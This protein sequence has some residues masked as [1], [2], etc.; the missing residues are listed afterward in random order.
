MNQQENNQLRRTLI[1]APEGKLLIFGVGLA[2]MYIFWLV[3]KLLFVPEQSQILV[4]VTAT[5]ILFGRA[6]AMALGYSLGL[7]HIT[8]IPICMV[9]ETV[10]VLIFYPLFVFS[11]RHLLVIKWLKKTFDHAQRTAE[12]H[13]KKVQRY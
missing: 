6:A 7:G 11:F 12:M 10:L 8:I 3:I 4:G 1:S 2:F 9:I 5:G 13:K